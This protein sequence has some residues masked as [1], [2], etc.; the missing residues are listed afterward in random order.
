MTSF[1]YHQFQQDMDT[2]IT[3]SVLFLTIMLE[4][5]L[6]VPFFVPDLTTSCKASSQFSN[7]SYS[8]LLQYLTQVVSSS[9]KYFLLLSPKISLFMRFFIF[10]PW[11]AFF[12]VAFTADFMSLSGFITRAS[13]KCSTSLCLRSTSKL[14]YPVQ[15]LLM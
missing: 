13:I 9:F 10:F 3:H 1:S 15:Q 14:Y 12:H 8:N 2:C 4:V 5:F 7:S 6:P 11:G